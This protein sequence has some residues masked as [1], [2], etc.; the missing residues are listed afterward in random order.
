MNVARAFAEW[1]RGSPDQ[2]SILWEV[3]EKMA[4]RVA[5]K[6]TN[7]R[8]EVPDI[9]GDVR[10]ELLRR[11]EKIADVRHFEALVFLYAKRFALNNATYWS[12]IILDV[13]NLEEGFEPNAAVAAERNEHRA[14]YEDCVDLLP[15]RYRTLLQLVY[16]EELTTQ[17]VAAVMGLSVRQVEDL[18]DNTRRRLKALVARRLSRA[19]GSG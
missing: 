12:R 18:K 5:S 16:R 8:G 3:F 7:S 10:L 11:K 9:L 17:Q 19:R 2:F 6:Y 13:E 4:Q 1:K 15:D 14:I